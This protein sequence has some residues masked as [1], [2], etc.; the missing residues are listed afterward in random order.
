[1]VVF[2][3]LV[4]PS[5]SPLDFTH[6]LGTIKLP[7]EIGIQLEKFFFPCSILYAKRTMVDYGSERSAKEKV[8]IP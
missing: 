8:L 6:D 2:L 7:V 5:A 4:A 1:M 3:L